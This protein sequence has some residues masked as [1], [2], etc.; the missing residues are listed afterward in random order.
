MS[1]ENREKG[2]VTK[3]RI[4]HKDI[5]ISIGLRQEKTDEVNIAHT[6]RNFVTF[7][8]LTLSKKVLLR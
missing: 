2:A 8:H 1:H 7:F 5:H 3:L 4:K 6:P